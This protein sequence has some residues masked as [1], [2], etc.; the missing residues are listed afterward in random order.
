MIGEALRRAERAVEVGVCVF[1]GNG[2]PHGYSRRIG[3]S[4]THALDHVA[5]RHFGN[6]AV[7][8][9]IDRPHPSF[10][11]SRHIPFPVPGCASGTLGHGAAASNRRPVGAA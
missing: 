8:P 1:L 10:P 4:G 5:D 3:V 9:E 7:V 11:L 6:R 2:Q